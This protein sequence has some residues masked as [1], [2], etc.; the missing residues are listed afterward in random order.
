MMWTSKHT[1]AQLDKST[2]EKLGWDE[3]VNLEQ[4]YSLAM[5]NTPHEGFGMRK[6]KLIDAMT[7][8]KVDGAARARFFGQLSVCIEIS[9]PTA[10]C[11]ALAI[12]AFF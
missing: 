10:S 9:L 7:G 6:R 5:I 4:L 3:L 12:L 8:T 1:S 11:L 2:R